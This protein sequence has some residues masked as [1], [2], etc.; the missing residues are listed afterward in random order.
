[1]CVGVAVWVIG[2]RIGAGSFKMPTYKSGATAAEISKRL[3][4]MPS[5]AGMMMWMSAAYAI[6]HLIILGGM[7]VSGMGLVEYSAELR[8]GE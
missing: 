6:G 4:D 2:V 3:E 8:R 5:P 1:M 7:V